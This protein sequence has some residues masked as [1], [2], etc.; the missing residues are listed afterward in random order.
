MTTQNFHEDLIQT[1]QGKL[2]HCVFG[3][4][5]PG[6]PL[7]VVHGG[8]G[9][10]SMTETVRDLA[11]ERPVHFYDQLGCGR[12]DKAADPDFYSP[13]HY[14]R[15]LAEV[16]KALGLEQVCLMG[17]SW[18]AMLAGLYL[19]DEQ[20][21]GV[22]A[23][24]LCAPLM[25]APS[26]DADQRENIRRMPKDVQGAILECER[27]G[28]YGG[29]AYQEA[30]MAYYR[31]HLC[32][33]DPWPDYIQEAFGKLDME[34]YGRLWG[35]SEFT[36]T[37]TLRDYDL[38]PR[39]HGITVPTLLTCGDFDEAGVKTLKNFQLAMPKA[40]LAVLPNASHLHHLEKPDLFLS[41]IRDF[42]GE[43]LSH[44]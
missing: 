18:G 13:E 3:A 35:P 38:L 11:D 12:S 17:F 1:T 19:L 29:E 32:R 37:G 31:R 44:E 41:I 10:L 15:E 2:W 26:W 7:L 5:K 36:I 21:A 8:P 39:L 42:L 16:R 23:V 6:I 14:V 25:G 27:S 40:F 20:Q 43:H 4:D 24:M 33:L 22:R 30:M 28:D 9:F 34:V